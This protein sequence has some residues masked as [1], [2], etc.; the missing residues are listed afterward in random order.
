MEGVFLYLGEVGL[1][2]SGVS[3]VF[4]A[5]AEVGLLP[6]EV[7]GV[8]VEYGEVGLRFSGVASNRALWTF[9]GW[10]AGWI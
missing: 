1:P 4:L 6:S 9:Q 2:S 8:L 3:V 10:I 5:F 7:S